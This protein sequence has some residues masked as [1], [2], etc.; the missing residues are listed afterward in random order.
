[1]YGNAKGAQLVIDKFSLTTAVTNVT[2]GFQVPS[3]F[4]F[5]P[6][7]DAAMCSLTKESE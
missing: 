4:F 3:V 7:V 5:A 2:L 6:L 1:M